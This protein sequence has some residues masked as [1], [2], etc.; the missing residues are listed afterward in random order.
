MKKLRPWVLFSASVVLSGSL[1]AGCGST[2][3]TSSNS[4]SPA[5]AKETVKVAADTTFPPFE[6]MKN[7]QV[8]GFDIDLIKAIGEKENFNVNISTMQFT[9]LIPALQSG[10][11]D[12]AVAGITIKKSRMQAVNFSNAYYRSGL[13]VLTKTDSPI[14]G[15]DDLK[16]KTVGTKKGT[17]SVDLLKK[18]GITNVKQFDN[19]SDAYAALE[20]GGVD[21]VL[22]DNP[23][24]LDFASSHKNVHVVGG[25]LTGEYYGIGVSKQKP[26]LLT[27]INDGL[28]KLQADGEYKKI[29]EKYF[30]NDKNGLVTDKVAP[31]SVA[32]N[33]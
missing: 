30:G 9:G 8:E 2:S 1:I 24:N 21:A 33:E 27:K 3:T 32:L 23:V 11:A 7:G 18:H 31:E 10:Q 13:S 16:T 29:Y 28:A 19:I 20:S 22:F 15:I 6:S 4:S 17:S 5:S 26:D 14:Q 25:L 12:V